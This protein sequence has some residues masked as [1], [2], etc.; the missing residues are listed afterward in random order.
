[1]PSTKFTKRNLN[2][3]RKVYPY[4]RRE[5]RYELVSTNEATIEIAEV[6][7]FESSTEIYVFT[8]SFPSRPIVTATSVDS[9][10]T[11]TADVNVFL[12]ELSSTRVKL[13]TSGLFTGVVHIHA[14]YV[15]S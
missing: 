3:Y 9:E 5:P 15:G 4:L 1:M 6:P 7:F 8:E 2:R 12:T 13:E 11:S 10:S 14:I